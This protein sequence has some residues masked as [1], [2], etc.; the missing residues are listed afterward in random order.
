M[1]YNLQDRVTIDLES[2]NKE[3]LI[4]KGCGWKVEVESP[5]A[6]LRLSTRVLIITYYILHSYVLFNLYLYILCSG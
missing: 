2:S 5:S 4:S 1:G 6:N 3:V